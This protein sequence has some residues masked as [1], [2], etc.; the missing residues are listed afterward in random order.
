MVSSD[1][2]EQSQLI[3]SIYDCALDP[4][5]WSP[6]LKK[7]CDSLEGHS[8]GIVLLDFLG[9]GDR[10][11]R[12]W[13]PT[14]TWAERMGGVLDSVKHIHRQF[15]GLSGPRLEEPIIL[16]RDLAPQVNVFTTPF[17]NEWA[18]P[19]RI[20]QVMEAVALSEPTRL[21]LLC[22]TR[23]DSRGYFTEEQV[24]LLRNLAPH[25]RR[26]ITIS[27]LL[28]LRIVERQAFAAVIDS[29]PTGICIVGEGGEILHANA[30]AKRM[31]QSK[32][33]IRSDGGRLS[34]LRKEGTAE[35]M[36]AIATAQDNEAAIGAQGIGVPLSHADGRAAIAHVLPLAHGDIR[37]RLVPQALAA[38]FVNGDAPVSFASLDAIA[39]S[40]DFTASETRLAHL[41]V[42]GKTISEAA[43][44]MGIGETTARTHLQHL[45]FKT[46]V[47]RQVDLVSMLNRLIPVARRQV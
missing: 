31:L 43:A 40:F 11:V 45:F 1:F 38:V 14:T 27:D 3:G 7:L 15:L 13:G 37:T 5:L 47:S 30:A 9:T 19:Q 21:G 17:Y 36:T 16:P 23:Q 10:L 12:D 8:A 33:P 29:L 22:V 28:D 26:A 25:I 2:V 39:R 6:T 35:L 18:L 44:E 24:G 20:H 4:T 41:L 46:G 42:V 32:G 34:G